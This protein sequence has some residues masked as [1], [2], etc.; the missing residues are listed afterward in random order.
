[1]FVAMGLSALAPVLHSLQLYG[2]RKTNS[3]IGLNWLV[4]QGVLYVL[5]A[6][7]YAA[8]VLRQLFEMMLTHASRLGYQKDLRQATSTIGVARIRSSIC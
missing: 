8:C 1:M 7:I 2:V 3:L 4:L 6:A 5:G